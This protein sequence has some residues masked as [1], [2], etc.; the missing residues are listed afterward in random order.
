MD[1]WVISKFSTWNKGFCT[2]FWDTW[3]GVYIGDCCGGHD[4][5]CSTRKFFNCLVDR[6]KGRFHATY[7]AFFGSVGCW[8]KYTKLMVTNLKKK[9]RKK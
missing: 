5:D 4:K 1:D 2:W 8:T 3:F 7:I 9:W 6:F